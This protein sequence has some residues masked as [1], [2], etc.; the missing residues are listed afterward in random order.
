MKVAITSIGNSLESKLDQ[1]FG[2]CG[3]FI[4]YDTEKNT[5]RFI[6]T[7]DICAEFSDYRPPDY[8]TLID[9]DIPKN[10]GWIRGNHI[11]IVVS[12]TY[13]SD[14]IAKFRKILSGYGATSVSFMQ[15]KQRIDE[16]IIQSHKVNLKTPETLFKAY[17]E[18]DKPKLDLRLLTILNRE[19]T[20]EAEDRYIAELDNAEA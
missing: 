1:R 14:E 12:R 9:K 16:S 3:F 18:L 15:E 7:Y 11:R 20:R 4:I 19:I 13:M 2:R 17:L 10:R 6:K 5:S 8:I